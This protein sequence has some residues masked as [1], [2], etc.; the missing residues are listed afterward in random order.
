MDLRTTG[1][2]IRFRALSSW[3]AMDRSDGYAL[4]DAGDGRRLERFGKRVVD[5]PSPVAE[6]P[7]D[8][9]AGWAKADLRFERDTGW[10]G[11]AGTTDALA[12]WTTTFDDLVLE[13]RAAA[14]GQVGCFPEHRP[15]W[16]WLADRVRER[17]A[18]GVPAPRVL[19][20]FAY[21]GA[22]SLAAAGA[23]ATV[24]HVDGARGAVAW[25]RRNAVLSGLAEQPI[26]WLVD[27]ATAFVGREL[28]RGTRY[29]GIVLDPPSYGHAGRRAWRLATDLPDLLAGCAGLLDRP[30]PFILLTAHTPGFEPAR[31]AELLAAS[32]AVPAARVEAAELEL[33]ASSGAQLPLGASARWSA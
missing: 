22:A 15:G 12:P 19:N 17:L 2:R 13:L 16:R 27:D 11:L 5:R 30:A 28:R 9:A 3:S 23:G 8:P 32:V 7:R 1:R 20:L 18:A 24:A 6:G 33:R 14:G 4:L 26:R 29:D 31:L 21:T 25:A 10:R